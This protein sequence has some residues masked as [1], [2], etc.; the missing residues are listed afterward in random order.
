MTMTKTKEKLAIHGGAPV[1]TLPFTTWPQH[2]EAEARAVAEVARSGKW[3]RCAYGTTE[4]GQRDANNIVGRSRA[5]VFE[6]LFAQAQGAK[7]ALG[8]TSGSAALEVALRA[9][10]IQPGDEVITTPYTF[11][12]TTTCIMNNMAVPVY[13]DIDPATY[14]MDAGQIELR[15]TERTRAILPVHFSGNLCDME[16]IGAIA[17]KH[18]LRVIEDAAHAHGVEYEG[19]QYAGTFG[20]FGCFSFQESK[21]LPTGEGGMIITNNRENIERVYSLHHF[22]RKEGEVWYKH[23]HQ[24]WNYRMNEFTAAIGIVQLGRLFEQNAR[25]MENY[26]YLVNKLAK[27]PGITPSASHPGLTKHSHH[28]AMLRYDAREVGGLHRNEF[29]KALAAE[30]IPALTGYTFPNYANPFMTS[31]E[32]RA[33]FRAAGISLPDYA[34]Y[35]ERCPHCEHACHEESI[36]LEHRLLLGTREDMDDIAEGF[37]KVIGAFTA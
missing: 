13:T 36:W 18:H 21:N 27:L 26:A 22:G 16:T 30:G 12:A 9:A 19:R 4:F 5:E 37:A 17:R 2:D 10:G 29:V 35:A 7:Y 23:F 31:E 6:D 33:R 1:R 15:I 14:N 34:A 28:L 32:T 11:I 24:G 25:R 20:D 3:W 8:V